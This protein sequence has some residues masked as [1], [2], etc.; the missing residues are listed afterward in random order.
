[1]SGPQSEINIDMSRQEKEGY[2]R[3]GCKSGNTI[4]NTNRTR[5]IYVQLN[6]RLYYHTGKILSVFLIV[7]LWL[8]DRIQSGIVYN[9]V[10]RLVNFMGTNYKLIESSF[11]IYV[12][13]LEIYFNKFKRIHEGKKGCVSFCTE[14]FFYKRKN[15]SI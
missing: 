1:M 3:N 9:N 6:F 12:V 2:I 5:V 13:K 7:F 8:W 10:N 4:T 14:V 11:N 15:P